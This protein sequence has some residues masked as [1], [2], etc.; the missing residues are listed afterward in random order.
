MSPAP[1]SPDALAR[2]G[3][4]HP[5]PYRIDIPQARSSAQAEVL[6]FDGERAIGE[7]TRY[8]IRFTHPR[9]DLSRS[10]YLNKPATFIIQPPPQWG[11]PEPARRVSGV[12]TAFA[13]LD[14][15][16]DESRYEVVLE[17]RM[18]LL[19]NNPKC[20]F[21]LGMN[22]P[23]IIAQILRENGFDRLLAEFEF[24]LYRTYRKREFVMQWH[25]DDLAFVTRLCRR[26]GIWYVC[27]EGR[28]CEKVRFGDDL[29]HYRRSP[30]LTVA[31][32]P[33]SGLESGGVESVD[34]LQ[35]HTKTIPT[36][37]TVRTF[38]AE[39]ELDR[40]VDGTYEI[41]D[42][43]T[44]AGEVYAWG[45]PYLSPQE[46]REEAQ[47][48]AEAA[49]AAQIGYRGTCDML[50]IA[51]GCVVKLSN[52]ELPDA[53]HGLLVVRM[54]C[55]AARNRGYRVTFSA[56]PSDRLYR[57]PL[58]EHEWPR[59]QGVVTGRIASTGGCRDPYLDEQG[60]YIV[61]LHLDRDTRTPGLNSCPMRLAKPFAGAGQSGFH[62]GLVE[63]T[64]VTVAFMWG[65]PDLPYISQVLHTVQETDPIVAGSPWQ[66]RN[67]IRTR[68]NNTIELEDREAS[69]H[70]KIATEHGKT[71]LNLGYTVDRNGNTRGEGF[72]LRTDMKGNVRGGG[73][74]HM[75]ADRQAGAIGEQ[76][77][78]QQATLRFELTQAQ[79]Q[80]LADVATEAKAEVTDVKAENRWLKEE[81]EDLKQAVIALSAPHGIGM[82]TDGRVM[83]SARGD[84]SV[85]TS[86]R[87]AVSAMKD[88]VLAAGKALSLFAQSLG[89]K[90]VAARGPVQIQAQTDEL[91]MASQRDMHLRST[92]GRVVIDADKEILLRCGHSYYRITPNA[93]TH[94]TPGDYIERAA[95]WSRLD[96]DG[97]LT[98]DALP[99]THDLSDLASHGSKFSG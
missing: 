33:H 70:I 87:F 84:A 63:G 7:P 32:R 46:A 75:S 64:V 24:T 88:I 22:D 83:V 73:G 60:R 43:A 29:T 19:R 78:M 61:D 77:D 55:S 52:R 11:E 68:S 62:F 82:A 17:S 30:A 65:N 5:Q 13:L 10:E 2:T 95:S 92:D 20:R 93:I 96:P 28:R 6:S 18:G 86:S 8:V 44:T 99:Y 66:T 39:S 53:K 12:T 50:D 58:L 69:E 4:P 97:K 38:S 27:E 21:F 98:R 67:T 76:T 94:A 59:V 72:E 41:R 1:A 42:D 23:D 3:D 36:R 47:L 14:S 45:A 34:T 31:Y 48:R 74:L 25:E 80:A 89:I 49:R 37:Y 51:P 26:S 56:M 57:L 85:A 35:M 15:S 54:T 9:H 16:V 40:P 81:L 71:Q 90:L 79:A 91:A